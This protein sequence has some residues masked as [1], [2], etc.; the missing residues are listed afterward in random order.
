MFAIVFKKNMILLSKEEIADWFKILQ[1]E[2]YTALET[3]LIL[4]ALLK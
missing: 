3:M 2:I 4:M 1:R